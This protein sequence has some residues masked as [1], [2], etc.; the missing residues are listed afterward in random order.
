M[1]PFRALCHIAAGLEI[2]IQGAVQ[3]T[4]LFFIVAA[5]DPQTGE[6]TCQGP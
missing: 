5:E 3:L 2:R 6:A 4:G 1:K